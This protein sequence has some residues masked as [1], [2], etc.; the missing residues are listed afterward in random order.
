MSEPRDSH[1]NEVSQKEKDKCHMIS[2]TC[3]IRFFK[4]HDTNE[5]I[6]KTETNL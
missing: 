5:L 2:F 1:T 3:G 4:K 6:H